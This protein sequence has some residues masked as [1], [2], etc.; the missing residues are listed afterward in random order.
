MARSVLGEFFMLKSGFGSTAG[1][2]SAGASE[3]TSRQR[4]GMI[5]R[6][7]R[8]AVPARSVGALGGTGGRGDA[9][10]RLGV[11]RHGHL[12]EATC[13]GGDC[14]LAGGRG[15]VGCGVDAAGSVPHH[16]IRRARRLVPLRN[17]GVE[18]AGKPCQR[19]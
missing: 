10:F 18:L 1:I 3:V 8:A 6:R 11:E 13:A 16:S 5:Q 12:G 7:G 19:T 4:K 14:R 2:A 9:A 17:R 15:F